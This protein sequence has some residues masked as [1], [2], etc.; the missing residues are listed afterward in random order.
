MDRL[1]LADIFYCPCINMDVHTAINT[2]QTI[3]MVYIAKDA[4]NVSPNPKS[5][6]TETR[7]RTAIKSMIAKINSPPM[8][9]L[10]FSS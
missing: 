4:N 2:T 10:P 5:V 1:L 7:I 3:I 9:Y 8:P 6:K